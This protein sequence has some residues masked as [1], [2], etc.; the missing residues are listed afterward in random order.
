MGD[1]RAFAA[2]V[3]QMMHALGLVDDQ[4]F[5]PDS[6][7]SP[8]QGDEDDEQSDPSQT[9]SEGAEGGRFRDVFGIGRR[10]RGRRDPGYRRAGRRRAAGSGR[11]R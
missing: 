4:P 11:G 8:D 3:L 5:S 1:Q 7:E 10:R 6:D 2:M 9:Q